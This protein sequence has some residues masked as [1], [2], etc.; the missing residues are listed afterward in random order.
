[1]D[2]IKM[3]ENKIHQAAKK[4]AEAKLEREKLSNEIKFL[5]EDNSRTKNVARENEKWKEDK[6]LVVN[7]VEKLLDKI[8][9]LRV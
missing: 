4:L 3:L 6:R 2:R 9:S 5:E 8:D 7:R 1:M